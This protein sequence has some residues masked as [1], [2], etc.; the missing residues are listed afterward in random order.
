MTS[1]FDTSDRNAQKGGDFVPRLAMI[2]DIAGFGRCST[3]VSLPVISVMKVQVCP[4]PTSVLS[5]H[6]GFPLCHFDDYTSH[7]RDYIKVWGEL[8]LTFDGLYCGFLGNEEQ[9]DIVRE[10]VEMFRPPLFLLDPVMGDHG[11]AYSSITEMHVQKMKELLPL[12]VSFPFLGIY[13]GGAA[14]FRAVGDSKVSMKV[15]LVANLVN[16]AG[17]AIL[18]YGAGIGA[19]GAA[20]STLFSRILSAVMIIVLLGKSDKIIVSNHWRIDTK[21]LGKIL[22]IGVPNGLENSIF[23]I[24]KL[25]TTSLIA[26]FGMAATTANAVTGSIASFQQIPANAI[27]VAMITVIGQC[28]GAG[29]TEQALYYLKKMMK[30]AYACMILLGIPMIIFARPICG[31]YHLS[32][33][34]MKITVFLLCYSC[35]CCMLV[36]P[37]SFAQSNALRAAGD[38]RF[39]MIVAIASMWLCRVGMAYILGQGLGL[40]V[41]GVWIA[42]TMDWVVRA[43]LFTNRI[44]TGKWLKYKD[45]LVK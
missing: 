43:F 40:G 3:T 41:I 13:N 8:G 33:E 15:S 11:R 14:L 18:I 36:H 38:V 37:L 26:G 39:T 1:N 7:M 23:Q 34:T 24:G 19:A 44:R 5:N 6:L 31:I 16:I 30:V 9:I 27:G 22:Y 12:A 45:R 25:L 20:L 2:N 35:V 17:N 29:E 21:I 10:F 42:M 32:P 28:I 4:V